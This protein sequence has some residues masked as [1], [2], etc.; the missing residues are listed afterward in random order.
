MPNSL[1]ELHACVISE[2]SNE[3]LSPSQT[4][5]AL[6][7]IFYDIFERAD[8]DQENNNVVITPSDF[9]RYS[10]DIPLHKIRRDIAESQQEFGRAA[11]DF[12]EPEILKRI[13]VAID[14]SVVSTVK[15]YT[16]GWKT[17]F[18][19]VSAGIISGILFAVITF[20][21]YKYVEVDPS[22]NAAGKVLVGNQK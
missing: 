17:F 11:A 5:Y 9:D 6:G 15:A 8:H 1:R 4:C 13:S 3:G 22:L 20:A 14:E 10:R 7:W 18:A 21:A 2:A 19:N 16:S 12:M